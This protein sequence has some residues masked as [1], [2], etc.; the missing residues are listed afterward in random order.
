MDG[1]C[2]G[3]SVRSEF[4]GILRNIFGHYLAG[5]SGFIQ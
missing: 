2:L 5:F 4:G 3:F 1:S